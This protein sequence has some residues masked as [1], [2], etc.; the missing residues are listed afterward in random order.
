MTE[1]VL[2]RLADADAVSFSSGSTGVLRYGMCPQKIY[3]RHALF[4]PDHQREEKISLAGHVTSTRCAR[5]CFYIPC[6][7]RRTR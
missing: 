7:S 1:A 3:Q 6:R 2:E 4:K 5:L